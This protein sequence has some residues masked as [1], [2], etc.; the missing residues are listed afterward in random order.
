MGLQLAIYTKEAFCEYMLPPINNADYSITLHKE[1]F[2][3][4][5]DVLLRLEITNSHWRLLQ[6]ET[7]GFFD[8]P[9]RLNK[10]EFLLLEGESVCRLKS[11]NNED[12]MIF[13]SE[14]S[15][16]FYAYQK[17]QLTDQKEITIGRAEKNTICFNNHNMVSGLHAVLVNHDQKWT[18]ENRSSNGL[19]VNE[20]YVRTERDLKF[21]DYINILGLH[22][23]FLGKIIAIDSHLPNLSVRLEEVEKQELENVT[24]HIGA[25]VV[26]EEKQ[27]FHR[28]PRNVEP[29][30]SETI[31]IE[32]PPAPV[33]EKKMPLLLTIGPSFT[34]ALPML[35]GCVMMIYASRSTGAGVGMFMY[36]G[37][38]MAVSSAAIG[39]AW[40]VLNIKHQK[41]ME[42][43][44]ETHRFEAY[45]R[46]LLRKTDEIRSKYE[47]NKSTLEAMYPSAEVC[48]NYG[49]ETSA[50]WNRNISHEDFLSYRI[51]LG[52]IDFQMRIDIPKERFSLIDDSLREKPALI[53]D[54]Y[55][56]LYQVPVTLDLMEHLMMGLIGGLHKEGAI[57]LARVLCV[58]MAAN[59]CYTDLKMVFL[60]DADDY[61]NKNQWDFAKW[62]PHVWSED[63]K[64]RYVAS[65]ATE[66]SDLCYE[67]TKIFRSREEAND[68]LSGKKVPHPF[69]VFYISDLNLIKNELISKYLLEPKEEYGLRVVILA[70]VYESLP[71]NCTFVVEKSAEFSGFYD[72]SAGETS[73]QSILFDQIDSEQTEDF[74][75]RLSNIQVQETEQ[76]GEIPN[77]LTFFD[78]YGIQQLDELNIIDRWL[79]NRTYEHISGMLGAKAESVPCVLDV[80]E[81][82]HGPHGLVAGTTGS[83]KSETLQTYL[84]SLAVNYSP[85]DVV[86]FIIDYKGGGMANLFEGLP[87]LIGQISNLSGNQVNRAMVSIK[88]ENRRR[89]RIFNENGVNNIN[90]YTK[91]YKN[92][93]AD[94][95]VPHLFIVIDEFAELKREE[96]DFMRELISVAQVGRSLGVHLILATQKPAGTVDD[97]IWSNSKF[98]LCLRVQDRQDS[99]D[100][101]HKADAAYIT[102]AG[103][104]YL[105]VGNDEVYEMFQ[106][107]WSGAAYTE[108]GERRK[109][110]VASLVSLIGKETA[111]SNKSQ[112]QRREKLYINWLSSIYRNIKCAVKNVGQLR[113]ISED[114]DSNSLIPEIYRLLE[115]SEIDYPCNPYNTARLEDFIGLISI[116]EKSSQ[117]EVD[118]KQLIEYAGK[119]GIKLPQPVEKTQL[120]AVKE[121][122]SS[123]AEKNNYAN[124]HRLWLPILPD[125]IYLEAFD[126]YRNRKYTPRGWRMDDNDWLIEV[127]A[128]KI[129]DPHNQAQYPLNIRWP[130]AGNLGVIGS[131]TSGKSTL[132]QTLLYSM[133]TCYSPAYLNLYIL[134]FSSK[135]LAGF[136]KMPHTGGIMYDGEFEKIRRF[137]AMLSV[138]SEE[139]KKLFRGGNFSQYVRANGP[140]C[141]AIIVVIDNYPAFAEKT[142]QQYVDFLINLSK[143]GVSLGIF[144]IV[145]ANAVGM[146]DLSVRIAENMSTV[147]TLQMKDK[148]DYAD[149]LHMLQIDVIP[150]NGVKGRGLY[151]NNNRVLEFQAALALEAPDDF[152]RTQMLNE[153]GIELSKYWTGTIAKKIPEIPDNPTWDIFYDAVE[154]NKAAEECY[155]IPVGYN[156]ENADIYSVDISKFFCYLIAGMPKTGRRNYLKIL[157]LS[158]LRKNIKITLI[159]LDNN[160]FAS[161]ATKDNVNWIRTYDQLLSYCSNDLTPVF[162]ERNNYKHYLTDSGYDDD[163]E[164]FDAMKKYDTQ[165]ICIT[166]L[167][168]FM[169]TIYESEDGMSGFFE[170]LFDK[171]DLHNIY[172]FGVVNSQDRPMLATYSA[173]KLFAKEQQGIHFG[174]NVGTSL[175]NFEYV[176][177]NMQ[178]KVLKPGLGMLPEIEGS[179]EVEKIVVPLFRK[180]KLINMDK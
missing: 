113:E 142:N 58:Q 86:F 162:V 178:S 2:L 46:Y 12:I 78:M 123:I 130:E 145:S 131:T 51:G 4:N 154:Q 157:I 105:Q 18:I 27:L 121:Y 174:G 169:E 106:S 179:H 75:R 147:L 124:Q 134:D 34:M 15:E 61:S 73:K 94:T 161:I 101:L 19:Y 23:V 68:G 60:Y 126:S 99:M 35:L 47:E 165:F 48:S 38:I 127:V 90:S 37:L 146:N 110:A 136:E 95:P 151:K 57:D 50:L 54:S 150:E 97:N 109:E 79:K 52:D 149:V 175:L 103:R 43:E 129:D 64:T 119:Q 25:H 155:K 36:S 135:M 65:N 17:Y 173:F 156:Y 98:R 66:V 69:Y 9:G 144:M 76:G 158:A 49:F 81:K 72:S 67:L 41:Q 128:G 53:R 177:F 137:F 30:H 10:K 6:G 45:S 20:E 29:L 87:H 140:V 176:P 143:E 171:G 84:L 116:F 168:K 40:S 63:K 166:N 138:E 104:G 117:N 8:L 115:N 77:V 111:R 170:N 107:G 24:V 133:V 16:S 118:F 108:D 71:N 5:D 22:M 163:D 114:M 93:E 28:A 13:V 21:G 159:D 55:K 59:N 96:P 39:V 120:E 56:R 148:F 80:H 82:Y 132:I 89:Q 44:N 33:L 70:D 160:G 88:S 74:A 172:F 91:L 92:N 83:G 62:L 167:M 1:H 7:Y 31:E 26:R 42:Q 32:E 122:I 125:T 100:M 180:N 102:Q 14:R 139:R 85:E 164:L 153:I 141:P 3:L 11:T 152:T 112:N